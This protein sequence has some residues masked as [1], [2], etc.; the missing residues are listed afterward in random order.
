MGNLEKK[1]GF[2][3]EINKACDNW[4]ELN[5][6]GVYYQFTISHKSIISTDLYKIMNSWG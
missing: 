6:R 1:F 3:G 5:E 2:W 4:P